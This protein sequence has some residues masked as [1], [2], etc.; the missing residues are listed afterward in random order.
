MTR[1][2]RQ[3]VL[4]PVVLGLLGFHERKRKGS[5]TKLNGGSNKADSDEAAKVGA[6]GKA[7]PG[8]S[9]T[10]RKPRKRSDKPLEPTTNSDPKYNPTYTR[11]SD[12]R[13]TSMTVTLKDGEFTS[14]QSKTQKMGHYGFN[15]IPPGKEAGQVGMNRGH[16][17]GAQLGG[18]NHIDLQDQDRATVDQKQ[19]L[20][21]D[22]WKDYE[23]FVT[24]HRPVNDPEMKNF[25][26]AVADAVKSTENGGSGREVQYTV[27]LQYSGDSKV[28]SALVLKA[29]TVD[30]QDPPVSIEHTIP[31][32]ADPKGQE[33][34][35][36]FDG[37]SVNW[38]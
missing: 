7:R 31:N 10:P 22:R 33:G 26:N 1:L 11:D 27:D 38:T 5:R 29:E 2:L 25:E 9:A 19:S 24:L 12:G 13:V 14:V 34:Y 18:T 23:N 6:K 35:T 15:G 16:I 3:A 32:V 28:P 30:G 17:L 21:D 37:D 8:K 36:P 20:P 4:I